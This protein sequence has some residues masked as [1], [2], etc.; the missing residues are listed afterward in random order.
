MFRRGLLDFEVGLSVQVG[1]SNV[2]ETFRLGTGKKD[3]IGR[4]ELVVLNTDD[5]THADVSPSSRLERP[6][7]RIKD[8]RDTSVELRIGLMP[9]DIFFDLLER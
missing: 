7:A 6:G 2:A 3:E 9:L 1:C 8:M 5:V 4:K